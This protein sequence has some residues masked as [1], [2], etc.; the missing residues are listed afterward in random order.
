MSLRMSLAG[1]FELL[2]FV[3]SKMIG[4]SSKNHQKQ[5][6]KTFATSKNPQQ[7]KKP[8]ASASTNSMSPPQHMECLREEGNPTVGGSAKFCGLPLKIGRAAAS[9]MAMLML[10]AQVGLQGLLRGDERVDCWESSFVHLTA[11]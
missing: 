3:E 9:L 7:N 2:H 4:S 1:D 8:F 6:K 11:G 5:N 10:H